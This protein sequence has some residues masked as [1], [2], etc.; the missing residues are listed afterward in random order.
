MTR[1]VVQRFQQADGLAVD[2]I[3]GPHTR[4]GLA[5]GACCP[6]RAR[7]SPVARARS[8]GCSG[9]STA[10]GSGPAW[11]TAVMAPNGGSGEALPARASPRRQRDRLSGDPPVAR[12]SHPQAGPAPSAR[13]AEGQAHPGPGEAQGR[14]QPHEHPPG[15]RTCAAGRPRALEH[16]VDVPAGARRAGDRCGGDVRGRD[17]PAQ[18]AGCRAAEQRGRIP[19]PPPAPASTAPIPAAV[20]AAAQDPTNSAAQIAELE[21]AVAMPSAGSLSKCWK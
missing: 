5:A 10:P 16:P 2:G 14:A 18:A 6:A 17:P 7:S 13:Q 11:L 12:K 20:S 1:A 3:V 21:A 4:H 15:A 8:S 19:A 9:A